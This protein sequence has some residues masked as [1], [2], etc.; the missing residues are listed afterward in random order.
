MSHD[1]ISFLE[2][3]KSILYPALSIVSLEI[4]WRVVVK[5]FLYKYNFL[6]HRIQYKMT[7]LELLRKSLT[8]HKN[9][10]VKFH[11]DYMP[12]LRLCNKEKWLRD[13]Y[14]KQLP[15]RACIRY[16]VYV[17][18]LQ[19]CCTYFLVTKSSSPISSAP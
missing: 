8:F 13:I 2:D 12:P 5:V 3:D 18:V 6:L 7:V 11:Y 10:P 4:F 1:T 14:S 17:L 16:L 15:L 19:Q 9:N